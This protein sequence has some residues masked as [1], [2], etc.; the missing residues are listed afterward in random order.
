MTSKT[1]GSR[2]PHGEV[3]LR[4][5]ELIRRELMG[6]PAVIREITEHIAQNMGKG[7]R[8]MLLAACAMDEDGTV[9]PYTVNAASSIELLHL[10]S[11]VHDDIVDDAPMRRGMASVQGRFGKEKAVL[12]GD[13]LVC[14][15]VGQAVNL[16]DSVSELAG[17]PARAVRLARLLI[18]SAEKICLG[19]L[20]ERAA[21]G[22][23]DLTVGQ[24]LRII[25]QKTAALFY[26][27]AHVGAI[28][29]GNGE[30]ETAALLRFARYF[31][32]IFQIVDDIKDYAMDEAS[33]QKTV[34]SDLLSGVVTLPLILGFR[35]D[36]A[37]RP[38]ALE[39]MQNRL[40]IGSCVQKVRE[41]GGIEEAAS[42]AKAFAGKA[43]AQLA[44]LSARRR[45][46]R[47]EELLGSLLQSLSLSERSEHEIL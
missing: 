19:E 38:I 1:D 23:L 8:T 24:Y 44:R 45:R 4:T 31:G 10:A 43:H 42:V 14:K 5:W 36:A 27:S 3:P 40:D 12:C 37:L 15:A 16:D 32:L 11:L 9:P 30:R 28:L 46:E 22:K 7:I 26:L 25:D 33:V 47:L 29:G 2:F 17:E 6:A 21:L 35:R 34:R 20:A 39:V 13:W 18:H 41:S